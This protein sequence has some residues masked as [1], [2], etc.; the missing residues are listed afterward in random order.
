MFSN[1]PKSLCAGRRRFLFDMKKSLEHK[2]APGPCLVAEM[3]G[4]EPLRRFP[5]LLP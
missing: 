3:K 4:F 2:L 1:R 5:D